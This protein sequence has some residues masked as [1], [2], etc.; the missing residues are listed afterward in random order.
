MLLL[1]RL[2]RMSG[3]H[4]DIVFGRYV[5]PDCT[6]ITIE[7]LT[8][9]LLLAHRISSSVGVRSAASVIVTREAA[10]TASML[11]QHLTIVCRGGFIY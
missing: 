8:L 4:S 1:E 9:L 5:R 10:P 2:F 3:S 7:R 11:T 6:S